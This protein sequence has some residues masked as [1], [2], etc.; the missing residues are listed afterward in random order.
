MKNTILKRL[1]G[2]VAVCMLACGCSTEELPPPDHSGRGGITL[3]Q[4]RQLH[5]D[6]AQTP[7]LPSF[8]AGHL[9]AARAVLTPDWGRSV[10][11]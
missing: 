8:I 10:K 3:P 6:I 7:V 1:S 11:T 9:S 2:L 5:T 4:V